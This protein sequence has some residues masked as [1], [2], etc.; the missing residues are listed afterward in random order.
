LVSDGGS[1]GVFLRELAA[2]YEAFLRG[3][4]SPLPPLPVQ[5]ADYAV[6]QRQWLTGDARERQMEYWRGRLAGAPPSL[7]LPTD[8]A[9]PAAQR[10]RGGWCTRM[11]PESAAV[12][13]RA[14]SRTEGVTM[15]MTLLAAW[16]ALLARYSG[17][18]DVVVGSPIAGRTRLELEGLIGFFVNLVPLRTDL[19]GDPT[20]GEILARVRETTWG[21]TRTPTSPST[22]WWKGWSCRA[23][24]AGRRWCR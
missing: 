12:G 10:F 14:L 3:E 20:F 24:R 13:A 6:W 2:L 15:Y 17:Q 16:Q 4:P 7:D 18:D 22:R 9:R 1:I 19:G 21:R 23:P 5:Y 11:L 8:R